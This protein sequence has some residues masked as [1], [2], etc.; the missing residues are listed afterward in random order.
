MR[1]AHVFRVEDIAGYYGV[2]EEEVRRLVEVGQIPVITPHSE[3][4]VHEADLEAY[5]STA[6]LTGQGSLVPKARFW[7]RFSHREKAPHLS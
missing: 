1:A 3:M 6:R 5:L 4:L 2:S 7:D